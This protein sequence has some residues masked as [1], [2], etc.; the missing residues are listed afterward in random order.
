DG[1]LAPTTRR[2]SRLAAGMWA[3]LAPARFRPAGG[4]ADGGGGKQEHESGDAGAGCDLPIDLDVGGLV[5]VEHVAGRGKLEAMLLV[6]GLDRARQVVAEQHA[7]LGQ[8]ERRRIRIER[9]IAVR[10]AVGVDVRLEEIGD[11]LALL[12]IVRRE[13]QE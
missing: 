6:F 10:A 3:S 7:L 1:A 2:A 4:G 11:R 13:L 8:L 5:G 12:P 9:L